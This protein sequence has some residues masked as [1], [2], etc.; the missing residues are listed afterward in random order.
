MKK[1][2]Y[3]FPLSIILFLNKES[4][5]INQN[6][7]KLLNLKLA[8]DLEIF[9]LYENLDFNNFSLLSKF[10]EEKKEITLIKRNFKFELS[11][12]LKEIFLYS[13]GEIVAIIEKIEGNEV[14]TIIRCIQELITNKKDIVIGSRFI[15]NKK[16]DS[17]NK[18]RKD[19]APMINKL[20]KISLSKKYWKINDYTSGLF[21][22]RKYT[23]IDFIK[24]LDIDSLKILYELLSLSKGKLE[25]SEIGF[26]YQPRNIEDSKVDIVIIWDIFVSLLHTILQ[27]L[28][29]RKAIS[30][31]IVGVSGIFVQFFL[32]Y[33]LM[34]FLKFDFRTAL[35]FGVISAASSNY[36][37]NNQLTFN[38]KKLKDRALILGL[39]KFIFVSTIP[40]I[41]NVGLATTLYKYLSINT[42]LSQLA[43]ITIGFIWN[44]LASSKLVWN[45]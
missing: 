14:E 30:F 4:K 7:S 34:I 12:L 32:C 31:G 5:N 13:K 2:N 40:I 15:N 6:L 8:Y 21:V 11:R 10:S 26:S 9:V 16:I 25:I 17:N 43:G 39:F 37:I 45:S 27:R 3:K 22:L 44:Y 23:C 42:F 28:V 18:N 29:P 19:F 1:L 24:K 33:C 36:L 41:A 35:P 38:R 20:A